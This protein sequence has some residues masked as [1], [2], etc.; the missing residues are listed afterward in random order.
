MTFSEL[1]MFRAFIHKDTYFIKT[2]DNEAAFIAYKPIF[3]HKRRARF[4]GEEECRPQVLDRKST[5]YI[6]RL[7]IM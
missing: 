4:H 2:G 1:S 7:V 5:E 6:K 3:V